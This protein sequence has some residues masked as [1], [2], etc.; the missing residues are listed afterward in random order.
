[1]QLDSTEGNILLDPKQ[2]GGNGTKL[3]D[4]T[5]SGTNMLPAG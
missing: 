5:Q 2:I 4:L 1:M 3:S